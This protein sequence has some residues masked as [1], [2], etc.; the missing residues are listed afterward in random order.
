MP[1]QPTT[2]RTGWP[3]IDAYFI[4][5]AQSSKYWSAVKFHSGNVLY[6]GQIVIDESK[7][8][9]FGI[10]FL[11]GRQACPFPEFF[12]FGVFFVMNDFK[13]IIITPGAAYIFRRT[14]APGFYTNRHSGKDS[15]V[16]FFQ[17]DLEFD[18]IC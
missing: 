1:A 2:I 12:V 13:K 5:P 4:V 9:E 7:V 11:L 3:D 18:R 16:L 6:P 10:I 8:N 14:G 15:Q 17:I